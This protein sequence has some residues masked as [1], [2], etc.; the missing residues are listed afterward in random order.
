MT[1]H[2]APRIMRLL[3]LLALPLTTLPAQT[4][5]WEEDFETDGNGTRYTSANDFV[6]SD[7]DYFAR[8]QGS[9][10][11]VFLGNTGTGT[12]IN[13]ETAD[14]S[15]YNGNFYYAWED[16][17]DTGGNGN[18]DGQ[19][20][21]N[22]LINNI[23]ISGVTDLTFKGLFGAN[24]L[25]CDGS[26]YD[27]EEKIEVYYSIDG[28]NE[29]LALCFRADLECNI[30]G[31]T[32]NEPFHHDPNCDGDGGEGIQL[33][34]A[35]REFTFSIPGTG[36][37][38]S[39]RIETIADAGDEE[40]A[41]D[42][43]RVEGTTTQPFVCPTIGGI[44]TNSTGCDNAA[45]N[46]DV[47]GLQNMLLAENGEANYALE[48]V[49]FSST[50]ANPYSGGTLL[51]TI[52]NA[53]NGT[54]TLNGATITTPG[55][56]QIY[57]R[58]SPA[59]NDGN[60][61]PT[62]SAT[63]TIN[64]APNP[65]FSSPGNYCFS[66]GPQ[67]GLSGG[68]P[69][70]G[71][72]TGN[73]VTDNG[74]TFTFDPAGPGV[75]IGQ[76]EVT[77]SVTNGD[78]CTESATAMIEVFA[79]PP[80]PVIE[81]IA[82]CPGG[83]VTITPPGSAG[84]TIT[85]ASE[86]FDGGGIGYTST[87]TFNDSNNDH[88]GVTDGSDIDNTDG[89]YS[90]AGNG[91][92]FWAAEDTDDD[93]G[94]TNDEQL[95]TL[96]SIGIGG[97]A[98]LMISLDVAAGNLVNGPNGY[99]ALD[100]IIVE[101]G[102]NINPAWQ[103][104]LCFNFDDSDG[105]GPDTS[106]E[107]L[108]YDPDCDG[109]GGE[110]VQLTPTAQNFSFSIPNAETV[111]ASATSLFIR[112]RVAMDANQEEIAFDNIL[113][114]GT[115]TAT[116]YNFWDNDPNQTGAVLLAGPASS[117][118]FMPPLGATS[119]FVEAIG[120]PCNSEAE[121]VM[122]TITDEAPS[123]T[124]PD[125]QSRNLDGNCNYQVEDF[126]GLA[127]ASDACGAVAISQSPP[128]GQTFNG[129]GATVV[130]LTAQDNNG[131]TTSCNMSLT[132]VDITPPTALCQNTTVA[133]GQTLSP[134][135]VNNGSND[136]C[137]DPGNLI[138]SVAPNTFGC[139]NIG[140]NTVTLTVEDEA[141]LTHTCTATVTVENNTP[142]PFTTM[143]DCA[144]NT[145][146]TVIQGAAGGIYDLT[147]VPGVDNWY[148]DA[149][150]NTPVA[151]L[152]EVPPGDYY[153]TLNGSN[154]T[155]GCES[156]AGI[157]TVEPAP[158]APVRFP[159]TAALCVDPVTGTFDP[160]ELFLA[161][162]YCFSLSG[163]G[164]GGGGGGAGGGGGGVVIPP[165]DP[166]PPGGGGG[167]GGGGGGAG[168]GGGGGLGGI[169]GLACAVT[170]DP[171]Y[172]S[173]APIPL[174][175]LQFWTDAAL[176]QSV[177]GPLTPGT[178]YVNHTLF[179]CPSQGLA[180]TIL[181][182]DAAPVLSASSG[183]IDAATGTFDLCAITATT[184]AAVDLTWYASLADVS[185]GGPT[186][187]I[188]PAD[189]PVSVGPG[190]YYATY[191]G[192]SCASDPATFTVLANSPAPTVP[193]QTV[194][195]CAG[196]P[197]LDR[198]LILN[199]SP[200]SGDGEQVVVWVVQSAP[201]AAGLTPGDEFMPPCS[202]TSSYSDANFFL[203]GTTD[204]GIRLQPTAPE[205]DYV[206]QAK[207]LDCATG[208]ESEL[209]T[210]TY[211]LRKQNNPSD[212][213]RE[214]GTTV[215]FPFNDDLTHDDD[216]LACEGEVS[217]YGTQAN[218][219][220][221]NTVAWSIS[222]GGTI[223]EGA[224]ARNVKIEWTDPGTHTLTFVVTAT[225]SPNC[226]STNSLEVTVRPE[227]VLAAYN[228]GTTD[229]VDDPILV[230]EKDVNT[231]TVDVS[232]D[233]LAPVTLQ[234]G[235][236]LRYRVRNLDLGTE[237]D[238]PNG[239]GVTS[240]V[241][242]A[243]GTT[244]ILNPGDDQT[245][246]VEDDL[247]IGDMSALVEPV[248]ITY[249]I[250][251]RLRRADGTNCDGAEILV[252][253]RIVPRPRPD[254]V[255]NNPGGF[256][257]KI[258]SGDLVDI[259]LELDPAHPTLT[260]SVDYEFEVVRVSYRLASEGSFTQNSYGPVTGSVGY[261]GTVVLG[262]DGI[263]ETLTHTEGESVFIRYTVKTNSL[264]P[265][266]NCDG[267]VRGVVVEVLPEPRVDFV[268]NGNPDNYGGEI[269][270]GATVDVQLETDPAILP[271]YAQE[272]VD[273]E[274]VLD[275]IYYSVGGA[276]F[277]PGY[278]PVAGSYAPD[279]SGSVGAV[280][281]GTM[282]VND[283]LTNSLDVPVT[284]RYNFF[285]RAL[286]DKVCDGEYRGFTVV[287]RPT[288]K[289]AFDFTNPGNFNGE[290]CNGGTVDI[291]L[292]ALPAQAALYTEGTDYEIRNVIVRHKIGAGGALT[293]GY[294]P[295]SGGTL[296]TGGAVIS[297]INETLSHSEAKPVFIQYNLVL[298][299]LICGTL[300]Y[301]SVV[302]EVR[303]VLKLAFDFVNPGNFFGEICNGET[304]EIGL[305]ALPDQAAL[306]TEGTDYEIRNVIV[307]HRIGA[308]GSFTD[309]YGPV[310]GGTLLTG[311]AVI[312]GINE[313]L[314][315]SEAEPVFVQYNL[316]LEDLIC[317]TLDYRSVVVEVLPAPTVSV[318]YNSLPDGNCGSGATICSSQTTDGTFSGVFTE[319]ILVDIRHEV[320]GNDA[321]ICGPG[322]VPG[323]GYGDV[324]GGT[325][326]VGDDVSGGISETLINTTTNM[327]RVSYLVEARYTVGDLTCVGER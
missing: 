166:P 230:C 208:C 239:A 62:A 305:D 276:P 16:I 201:P 259:E 319:L 238:N 181:A 3:L 249:A 227:P 108:H 187:G 136:S 115:T 194:E 114:T 303:P 74:G 247:L 287:A 256:N 283:P 28:G 229:A 167:T 69:P 183:C 320:E 20:D 271:S 150:L 45:F 240:S 200:V 285:T 198:L 262:S 327:I 210:E 13:L 129:A 225:A 116:A 1:T 269:C 60:C 21:K 107:P 235:E 193:S 289:L 217:I 258:C 7:D 231:N 213:F 224:N 128:A 173:V 120:T 268:F 203:S 112:I 234:P 40:M 85:I 58:L 236:Q 242:D 46:I 105:A 66:D 154:T 35:L 318:Q 22:I 89:A 197:N 275:N 176:T 17:D 117:Y 159:G 134:A 206:F 163:G 265:S 37:T 100:Y 160:S 233:L 140:A 38:L 257:G 261:A 57:A 222:G 282:G 64:A 171:N 14:Y 103:E 254:F 177:S 71:T 205:G 220:G 77:Y 308:A 138:L 324:S 151:N 31:D 180:F 49:A 304:V 286:S 199:P 122:I 158:Y 281:D 315:H 221:I 312:S 149:G 317:G 29:V 90:F 162:D 263:N 26:K 209:S 126:T 322:A 5:I 302:V 42:W 179:A 125:P 323:S 27:D 25:P 75:V 244:F 307:R 299:D 316:V 76:N 92:L 218:T 4:T 246:T 65:T 291:D 148:E 314:S 88:W 153:G 43:L 144:N 174:A 53:G 121:E 9:N 325:L 52:L 192:T 63:V 170:D 146:L 141:G 104:G 273:Y 267:E 113:V 226:S 39:L 155:T 311:G 101:Y 270:N 252:T 56:Y 132:L 131:Q 118:T 164:G 169:G 99:D 188:C 109:D 288:L 248:E 68:S 274:F 51:G 102:T 19:D 189:G 70:G 10:K 232:F 211:T 204:R 186:L 86:D 143:S 91:N 33:T 6:D 8:I 310:S 152:A 15:G 190:T 156:T 280:V 202:S 284:I 110:G 97:I 216:H 326:A 293:E 157:F 2:F 253:A 260:E 11:E 272:G 175:D 219:A 18:P 133:V 59:P 264:D 127:T 111:D 228:T 290:I 124:C 223:L 300:D 301:R 96:N 313:T 278:G 32:S 251:P 185:D 321:S 207:V 44:S 81:D 95:L 241:A 298:E 123:I 266:T 215:T 12:L 191:Q 306:Y 145:G 195:F 79:V 30:S 47:T 87:L 84:G 48:L 36:S 83:S 34:P 82:D 172:P 237:I 296:L 73:G 184:P 292:D 72:Y 94:N 139:G 135:A 24:S 214:A 147:T 61:R 212:Q 137:T 98:D 93:G 297:G 54:A 67:G 196:A 119:I 309:S 182:R 161:T 178:Y 294:G 250:F 277:T 23:D 165:V 55:T 243:D 142:P 168:G 130:V 106:N 295:I 78:N 279:A 255:F 41:M 50:P 80:K 245:V